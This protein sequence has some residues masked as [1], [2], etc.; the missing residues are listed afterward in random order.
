MFVHFGFFYWLKLN[1]I[2]SVKHFLAGEKYEKKKKNF[3]NQ[4]N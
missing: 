1:N 3:E 2:F 4:L